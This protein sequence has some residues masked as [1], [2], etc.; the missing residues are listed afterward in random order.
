MTKEPFGLS[1][2]EADEGQFVGFANEKCRLLHTA[3]PTALAV[4]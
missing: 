1:R 2:A 4:C 3:C